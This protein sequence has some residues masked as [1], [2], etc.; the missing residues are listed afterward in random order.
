LVETC[1]QKDSEKKNF[2]A[3][4]KDLSGE[5]NKLNVAHEELIEVFF[6]VFLLDIC[7]LLL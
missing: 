6:G 2:D 7:S 4:F 3:A 1:Q 5:H